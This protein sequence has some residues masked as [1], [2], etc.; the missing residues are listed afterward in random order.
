MT[1]ILILMPSSHQALAITPE[2]LGRLKSS[3]RV[4]VAPTATDHLRADV[5]ELLATAEIVLTGTGTAELTNEVLDVAPRLRAI[6]HAAGTVRPIVGEDVYDR[7][8]QISSQSPTN[9]LPVAEYTLAMILLELKGV[10]AIENIYRAARAEVDVDGLLRD[11]GAYQRRVGIISASSIGR[12]MIELLRPF[13]LEV[14][15][16]D[17]YLTTEEA[18]TLGVTSVDLDTLLESSDLVS[19]H[20][21]L[22]PQTRGMIGAREL[23]LL[24]DGAVVINT[25]RGAIVDQDAFARELQTGR[26]RAVIDVTDPEVPTASS[27]LWTLDNVVLTPH[28]A[29][30]R[31]LELH[32]IG[33]RAV[34]EVQR[35]A[36]GDELEFAVTRTRYATNA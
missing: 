33:D 1:E 31:G 19:I 3:G 25:S 28:V 15:V 14:V 12:R 9:A 27:P 20:A 24:R 26:I 8:I 32:R 4:S 6:V 23:S 29:G 7:G 2:A 5:R 30:S 21:P 36:R 34:D 18:Q 17:P 22:L 13:D 16:Y 11:K 35:F 10:R